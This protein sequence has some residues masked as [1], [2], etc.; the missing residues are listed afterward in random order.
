M[1]HWQL[2]Q[3]GRDPYVSEPVGITIDIEAESE[4][5]VEDLQRL[6]AA[7]KQGCFAEKALTQIVPIDHRLK[8]GDDWIDV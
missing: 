6:I 7:A 2:Q 8:V 1:F 5:P 3:S 4:A